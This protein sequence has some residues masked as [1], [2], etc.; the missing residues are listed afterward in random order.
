M[1]E[2][3]EVESLEEIRIAKNKEDFLKKAA[4]VVIG[5]LLLTFLAWLFDWRWI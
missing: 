1:Q 4:W 2:K 5:L 3:S